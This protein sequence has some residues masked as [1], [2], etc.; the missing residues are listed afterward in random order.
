MA[1]FNRTTLA[2]EMLF[3]WRGLLIEPA[4]SN[5]AK[6][7]ANRKR[8][9]AIHAG[10][11]SRRENGVRLTDPGGNPMGKITTGTGDVQ[12]WAL[13]SLLDELNVTEVDFWSLDVEGYEIQVLNGV[14]FERHRPKFIV[15]EVWAVNRVNVFAVMNISGYEL[16]V[17]WDVEMGISG[18]PEG[19]QHRDFLWRDRR[20]QHYPPKI[21]KPFQ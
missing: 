7:Q 10:L 18:F 9:A 19:I 20:W 4:K 11:V 17:G 21:L 12:G 13:S 16:V 5:I 15:I 2:L 6:I 8:S 1:H 14:D 3:G